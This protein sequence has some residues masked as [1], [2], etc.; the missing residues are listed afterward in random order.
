MENILNEY[1]IKRQIIENNFYYLYNP[2]KM[3][4]KIN[5]LNK[6]TAKKIKNNEKNKNS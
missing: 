2:D 6:L 4:K 1:Y 3:V 5:R